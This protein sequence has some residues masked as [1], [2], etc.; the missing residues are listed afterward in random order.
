MSH[1]YICWPSKIP[2]VGSWS[3]GKGAGSGAGAREE[4]ASER[5]EVL[6][7]LDQRK[8]STLHTSA[9]L[10]DIQ[11]TAGGGGAAEC[12]CGPSIVLLMER[13]SPPFPSLSSLKPDPPVSGISQECTV[14]SHNLLTKRLY[15][16]RISRTTYSL[17]KD[18]YNQ[19]RTTQG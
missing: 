7:G 19:K 2:H 9:H 12:L 3:W 4:C 11:Q 1:V 15:N 17:H 8:D 16:T 10:A 18:M 13:A 14:S 5:K 6:I